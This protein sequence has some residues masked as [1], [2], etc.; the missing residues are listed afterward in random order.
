MKNFLIIIF[1]CSG[2]VAR[3]QK[4]TTT[5]SISYG[6]GKGQIKPILAKVDPAGLSSE[7]SIKTFEIGAS[8]M[9]GNHAALDIGF[10]LLEHR[11]QYTPLDRPGRTTVNKTLNTFVFPVKLKVD[12]LKYLF[13]SGGFLLISDMGGYK[14]DL[15]F[16]IGAGVQYYY[17][18]RYGIFIYPQTN[19]HSIA[20]GLSEEHVAFG[21]AYRIPK[22]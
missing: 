12:I 4:G 6:D 13:I 19:I 2:L 21:I 15:G 9:I 16:G 7:G 14:M 8:G 22:K 5:F 11:Y 1:L 17:K 20:V 3:A 10:S 18:N